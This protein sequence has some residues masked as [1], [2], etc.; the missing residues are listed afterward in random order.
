MKTDFS[1]FIHLPP[2]NKIIFFIG[3]I[4]IIVSTAGIHLVHDESLIQFFDNIHWT[5]GTA[6][7]AILAGLGYHKNR[8]SN[9]RKIA[10]WFFLGFSGYAIGQI[11]WD[12]QTVFF[13]D[14][15]PSPSD[16]FYLWLGPC[17]SIALF[18]EIRSQNK[19]I[20]ESVFWL[21]LLALSVAALTLILVSYL[22]RSGKLDVLSM[23]VL[24]SY[25]ITLLIPVLMVILL[26]PSMRLRFDY[27]LFLFLIGITVTASS[28]MH[29]NSMALDGITINGSWFNITFSIAILIAGLVVS[30]WKLTISDNKKFDRGS[31][32]LLRFLPLITVIFSS[33]AIII[34]GTNPG[35]SG[36]TERLVYFGA[37]IVIVLAIIRQGRQLREREQLLEAQSEILKSA[38]LIKTIIQTV[39][40]RIFWKDRNLNYLGCNDLFARDAGFEHAEQM[41]GKSDFEMGW[42]DQ[43]ELY[44]GDDFRVIESGKST[45]GYEEPQTTPDGNQIWLRTSKVPLIDTSTG[46]S[47]G[48]LG[49]YDD[50]T[51]QYQTTERLNFALYGASDGLWDWNMES[52]HVYYSPRW[53]EMLGYR[54]GDFPETLDTW[55]I[56]IHPEDKE[57]A[58]SQIKDYLE[59][60]IDKFEIEF[61]MKHKD[62]HWV[63]VLSRAKF[64]VDNQGHLLLPHRLVGTHVDISE[65]N[66]AAKKLK[67]SEESFRSLFDS[68]EEAV[69]VQDEKGTF[70]AVNDG[71]SRMYLRPSEWFIGKNPFDIS[72]PGKNDL[73]TLVLL[74]AKAFSGEPQTFEFW[75]TRA[76]GSIFPK[77]VHLTKGVWFGQN[78]VIAVSLDISER[79]YQQKQLEHIAH[80][81]A[82]TNLPNRL[83][84][85]DRLQHAL[86]QSNRYGSIV[87]IIYLDLDGFKE[88]NDMYGHEAGDQ[89]LVA[90]SERLKQALRENETLSRFGGDEFVAICQDLRDT[91]EIKPILNRL[92]M[93]ASAPIKIDSYDLQVS[94][95]I[96]VTFYP[97]K[98]NIDADQLIRQADQAMY[99]AKQSGKNRYHIFD[100]DHEHTLREKHEKLEKIQQAL[101]NNEFVLY[102]Q[103]KINMQTSEL[104][105]A[106][107]LIRWQNSEKGIIPPLEFLPV[108][109]NHPLAIEVGEWVINEAISQIKRWQAKG[110]NLS[111]S[112]NVGAKQLLQGNFVERIRS[113]LARYEN[114]DFSLLEI[115]ILETSAL[116]DVKLASSIIEECKTMNIH[117]ALDDFGT[118]YSSL[119]YLKRLPVSTL[120]IDQSFVRDMLD[121]SDD[122]AIL[123]G[124]VGLSKAFN[125]KVIAEGVET[126]EHG[127]QLLA[128]GCELV[129]GYGIARPMPP[130][131]MFGWAQNWQKTHEWAI[132]N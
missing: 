89:L 1:F 42:K 54:Y 90:I 20:N 96:G 103:P 44:R 39:P 24:V 16:L 26:I 74:H 132:K 9:M 38:N 55:S 52:N 8:F 129:Q 47:I 119:T 99:T 7:A 130:E 41:I 2:I 97:Q 109:E 128:I 124:I 110:L 66:E 82:L 48:V 111:V 10:Y 104:I 21:D 126:Y 88:V 23:T 123:E 131:Q 93:S 30:D 122:L 18:Y 56:L 49:I 120:K 43:A 81:D 6:A 58:L 14:A 45:L 101:N 113:I 75:G 35:V 46:E 64:A 13:Y 33:I 34:V 50:I 12:I 79:K 108:I 87:A 67:E 3:L 25:P 40:L 78:V 57:R 37:A 71:A 5:F 32:A 112:V 107:A 62:S 106:E 94:A 98:E 117:F 72:A 4:G 15:F 65:L 127:R 118:G 95:S 68:L 31:E 27:K 100:I 73:D 19:K 22:P 29:W 84:L 116:E 114:F 80:F 59:G 83:L 105:G 86:A 36:L 125:R 61:R 102:Y 85:S 91:L 70:L 69:Y 77:E 28:W 76:N 17:I 53:F 92:L 115:E 51:L 11:V 63:D 60:L 121:D